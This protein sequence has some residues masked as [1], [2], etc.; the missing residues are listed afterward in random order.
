MKLTTAQTN[1][2]TNEVQRVG[3]PTQFT[4]TQVAGIAASMARAGIPNYTDLRQLLP[5]Y[6]RFADIQA[7]LK[8]ESPSTSVSMATGMAHSFQL[9]SSKQ[10]S[11]F[12]E[13]LNAMLLHSNEDISQVSTEWKYVA[14]TAKML[15]LNSTQTLSSIAFV[16]RMGIGRGRGGTDLRDFLQRLVQGAQ[17]GETSRAAF[18]MFDTALG[19]PVN[20]NHSPFMSAGGKFV[21]WAKTISLLQAFADKEQHNAN[22]MLPILN[23]LFGQQGGLV[24]QLLSGK[25]ADALYNMTLSQIQH[26]A[27]IAKS[28]RDLNL[29]FQGQMT[30]FTSTLQDIEVAFAR[31]GA[32]GGVT[33]FLHSLNVVLGRILLFVQAHP[34]FDR[35]AGDFMMVGTAL[36]LIVGPFLMFVGLVG[37]LTTF[38]GPMGAFGIGLKQIGLAWKGVTTVAGDAGAAIELYGAELT[39][40]GAAFVEWAGEVV[41]G[42]ATAIASFLGLDVAMGPVLVIIAAIAVAVAAAYLIWKNWAFIVRALGDALRWVGGIL[43]DIGGFF[44][45]LF[46]SGQAKGLKNA[47]DYGSQMVNAYAQGIKNAP[48]GQLHDALTSVGD[49]TAAYLRLHSPAQAGPLSSLNTWWTAFAPTLAQ[50]LLA[51]LG[52]L[53]AAGASAA[54]A[55][56]GGAATG[57]HGGLA[58]GGSAGGVQLV[59][60]SGAIQINGA[61]NA[62]QT[63]DAVLAA[64]EGPLREK[65]GQ[66]LRLDLRARP[67][68]AL[69]GKA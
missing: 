34:T 26:T 35:I 45:T 14:G 27:S 30:Q 17:G 56:L 52:S 23:A 62:K 63:A 60:A 44:G 22:M 48:Q 8:G 20:G 5:L 57:S 55:L 39:K 51:D 1:A 37:M 43:K 66:I 16:N 29:T 11:P 7:Y 47:R 25:N 12:L 2:L 32:L 40:A 36:A 59:I 33:G 31:N 24:A 49:T 54:S 38:V 64:L 21:G 4:A 53:E 9:Y 19:I 41:M 50:G 13:E 67:T 69:P 6:T 46:G 65:L 68:R 10:L 42:N 3:I 61:T 58:G 28:Q 15:G 18:A